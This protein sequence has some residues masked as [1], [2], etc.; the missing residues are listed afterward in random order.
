M[1][2]TRYEVIGAAA[3]EFGRVTLAATVLAL[4]WACTPAY[5]QQMCGSIES[6]E[7]AMKE[8]GFVKI[9]EGESMQG[10]KT[11]VYVN[12]DTRVFD[13]VDVG[14]RAEGIACR[15]DAGEKWTPGATIMPG[16]GV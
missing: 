2:P 11:A 12:P 10:G 5:A 3:R 6:M 15:M 1:I 8:K 9:G 4:A 14:G 16:K 13:I 7:T